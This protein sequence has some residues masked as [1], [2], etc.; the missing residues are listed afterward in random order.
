MLDCESS[1]F[2]CTSPN[3][4]IRGYCTS[5]Y[6]NI[7]V[8]LL[9][10]PSNMIVRGYC[11]QVVLSMEQSTPLT[12]RSRDCRLINCLFCSTF[13]Y[14]VCLFR[15]SRVGSLVFA[16][17]GIDEILNF[18]A[19]RRMQDIAEKKAGD[20]TKQPNNEVERPLHPSIPRWVAALAGACGVIVFGVHAARY[21]SMNPE[22]FCSSTDT[23]FKGDTLCVPA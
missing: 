7:G 16:I 20:Q 17:L 10:F 19:V 9:P 23:T 14:R 8:Y 1:S 4:I 22:P 13:T 21:T 15:Y 11:T 3:M 6:T 5:L 18:T 12:I 2:A